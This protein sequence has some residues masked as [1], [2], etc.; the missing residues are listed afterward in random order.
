MHASCS[1]CVVR[2]FDWS[3]APD[4]LWRE[5]KPEATAERTKGLRRLTHNHHSFS[6]PHATTFLALLDRDLI[7]S[8]FQPFTFIFLIASH[9]FAVFL[10]LC[11]FLLGN[12]TSCEHLNC[13]TSHTVIAYC[14]CFALNFATYIW[15]GNK[16]LLMKS[17][18]CYHIVIFIWFLLIVVLRTS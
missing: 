9:F 18:S 13:Q 11:N 4:G 12:H 14:L 17:G 3:H 10:V 6:P 8:G 15:S 5:V 16:I 1:V 7:D 2:V